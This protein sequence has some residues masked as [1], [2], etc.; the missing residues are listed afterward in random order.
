MD[1]RNGALLRAALL[2]GTIL[3]GAVGVAAQEIESED[4]LQRYDTVVVTAQKREERLL[5]VPISLTALSDEQL[6]ETG[7]RE[8]KE[9]GEYVPNLQISAGNNFETTVT[10]RGVGAQSRNIGFDGRVGIYLDG[11]FLGQSQSLN[12]EL[13]DLERVEVLR[14][15]QGTLF[16]KNT[17]AGAVNIVTKKPGDEFEGEI[18]VDVGNLGY[19]EIKGFVNVPLS[20]SV[21]AKVSVSRALR[22][23]YVD[24]T[25][26]G[27]DLINTDSWAYRGQLRIR[28]NDKWDINASI[29]GL[30]ADERTL[31]GIPVTDPLGIF[32]VPFVLD[33]VALSI[34]PTV[35]RDLIGGALEASYTFDNDYTLK[36]ITGYRSSENRFVNPID[37]SA[38]DILT[39]DYTD[40]FD[41]FSEELQIISP[42]HGAFSYV[43]GLYYF[44]LDAK[45]NRE[46]IVGNDFVDGIV[47]TLYN[48]GA[49][50]AFLPP[51]PALSNQQVS[52]LLGNMDPIEGLKL[53]SNGDVTTE[54]T[55]LYF[56]GTYDLT[57]KMTL[58]IGARY[59]QVEKEGSWFL[60]GRNS[61]MFP[62]GSTGPD[63]QNP[64]PEIFS[65]SEDFFSPALSL[66][67]A[68][69][70]DVNIYGK[71]ASGFKSGG[72]NL[73]FVNPGEIAANPTL[74]FDQES[75]DNFEI[76]LK[77]AFLDNR[78]NLNVAAFYAVYDDFQVQQQVDLGGGNTANRINNA[79]SVETNG[80]ELEATFYATDDLTLQG[81]LGLLDAVYEEFLGGGTEGEDVSGNKLPASDISATFS[82]QYERPISSL[83]SVLTI[84]GD[85]THQGNFFTTAD[86]ITE[87][88]TAG[89]PVPFGE[90]DDL[91]QV[92]LRLGLVSDNGHWR[93]Y[94]WGRNLNDDQQF[95]ENARGFINTINQFPNPG[96]TYGIELVRAF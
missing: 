95:V 35:E 16:G 13:L 76:G 40:T 57:D 94:L 60:D 92:N 61:G 72:F 45:T 6:E 7:V 62:I 26:T 64:T 5:D 86:N 34:D 51:A 52:V 20:D 9:V 11:V 23:G 42:D 96:R 83:A 88:P 24:N 89:G 90:V 41:Q 14:G 28:P 71:F 21:A 32:P 29:D 46:V 31:G 77:G 3:S 81:S 36:S 74:Q 65:L 67:Y 87:F 50:D 55:A 53:F 17:V 66:S 39:V 63:K 1:N 10:I 82:V 18:G 27:K 33:Q 91:T 75:V 84:R 25:F 8:L 73:D 37:Y 49:F 56:N 85:V 2:S 30:I 80:L 70:D 93:A 15:P 43:A 19:R 47:G 48:I 79:G 44:N 54:N 78:L 69:G 58:G 38:L 59:S 68:L 22:D 12:Q 4:T